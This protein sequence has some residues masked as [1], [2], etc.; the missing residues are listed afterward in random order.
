MN[1][2]ES[3]VKKHDYLICLDSD[4]CAID[5]MTV[6][7]EKCFGP[8]LIEVF[9]L[10]KHRLAMLEHWNHVNLYAMTRGINRFLGLIDALQYAEQMGDL[11]L[12]LL[13]LKNWSAQTN[14]LSNAS[15]QREIEKCNAPVL[16]MALRWSMRVNELIKS[17]HSHEKPAFHG[18]LE[19]LRTAQKSADI[20]VVSAAN[21]A[22]VEEEWAY[23]S[24]LESVDILMTQEHGSKRACIEKLMALGYDVNHAIML[25]DAPGDFDAAK[26]N[27]CAFYPIVAGAEEE[28]WKRF[29][30]EA[31]PEFLNGRYSDIMDGYVQVFY[32]TLKGPK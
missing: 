17:L 3:L 21:Y 14:E 30:E 16:A 8:A 24:L 6:K 12:D 22:A 2:L 31:L 13:P 23:N 15:L 18:V 5:G 7:H 11:G 1:N 27:G 4:G 26:A 20:A 19:S 32:R 25:G 29:R 10:K 28:S 9:G